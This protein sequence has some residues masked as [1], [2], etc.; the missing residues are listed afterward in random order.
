MWRIIPIR[1]I[2]V[3]MVQTTITL[4]A[5]YLP[6]VS[7]CVLV[8]RAA[9]TSNENNERLTICLEV[10][11]NFPKQTLRNRCYIN[12]PQGRQALSV[13]IDKSNFDERAKC[14]TRDVCISRQHDWRRQHWHALETA[15]Y[16][17]PFFE[18][19]ADDFR[20]VYDKEWTS[21]VALNEAMLRVCLNILE[22]DA[23]IE[24]TTEFMRSTAETDMKAVVMPPYYQVFAEK[25]G[26]IED[27]SIIDL[28]FNLGNEAAVYLNDLK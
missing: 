7:W 24:Y 14:L 17:S 26:F 16:N 5:F 11:E 2:Y 6:P 15:Y 12:M 3:Y 27:M 4:P 9:R 8:A 10:C 21:L 22:I 23:D 18:Y 13:P 1:H 20:A 19:L 25:H 28:I